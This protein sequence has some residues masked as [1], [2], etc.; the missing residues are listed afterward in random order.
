M[1]R[2]RDIGDHPAIANA[3]ATGYP[4]GREHTPENCPLCGSEC[5]KYYMRRED[6]EIVGCDLCLTEIEPWEVCE[7]K[8]L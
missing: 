4:G 7:C 2:H 5:E 6:G 3:L 8:D 1:L